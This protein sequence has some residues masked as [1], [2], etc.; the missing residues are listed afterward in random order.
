[1]RAYLGGDEKA[2]EAL[3]RRHSGKVYGYLRKRLS[4]R[5]AADEVFQSVFLKLH[6]T[7]RNYDPAYPFAQWLFVVAK[8]TLFDHFRKA[9]RQVKVSDEPFNEGLLSQNQPSPALNNE[10]ELEALGLLP[11]K[12]RQAI[13]MRVLDER[14]YEEIAA[15]LSRSQ[16]NVR[17]MVSRGLKKLRLLRGRS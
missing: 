8:T 1:M 10:K 15:K 11:A 5:A 2:F 9:S 12:Q 16:E 14:S 3:Y 7:R 6:Q 17:Q 13:E 4:D